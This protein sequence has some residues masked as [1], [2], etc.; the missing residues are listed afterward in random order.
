MCTECDTYNQSFEVAQPLEMNK[1]GEGVLEARF[2]LLSP[3]PNNTM[4][5]TA[6]HIMNQEDNYDLARLEMDHTPGRHDQVNL[7]CSA[8]SDHEPPSMA[9]ITGSD[10][11][12]NLTLQDFI[13]LRVGCY[14]FYHDSDDDMTYPLSLNRY[15]GKKQPDYLKKQ[16]SV[17]FLHLNF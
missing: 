15:K 7:K 16:V 2:Q 1:I 13:Q 10:A 3:P 6:V 14:G 9:I 12:I 5:A 11:I 17:C 4:W 8:T